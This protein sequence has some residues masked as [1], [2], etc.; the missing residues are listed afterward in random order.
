M[1]LLVLHMQQ[2]VVDQYGPGGIA[3]AER[4]GEAADAAREHGLPVIFVRLVL[5]EGRPEMQAG[6]RDNPFMATFD[7]HAPSS[8]PH[9][10]LPLRPGDLDVVN[11]RASAFKGSDLEV[12]L[13]SLGATH[14]VVTGIG[15][16]GVVL[17][18]VIDAADRDYQV[19]VLSDACTDP[20][21]EAHRVLCSS[22]FPVRGAVVTTADWVASL[23]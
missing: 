17:A 20:D 12:L 7:E 13:R 4:C 21:E 3:V 8:R 22:V 15:T 23:G 19:T 9:E 1:A 6:G 18:T 16:T 11:K 10:L 5:R 2:G 14:V